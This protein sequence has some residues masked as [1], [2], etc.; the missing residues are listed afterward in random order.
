MSCENSKI[1]IR[2]RGVRGSHPMPGPSTLRYGGNTTCQEVRVDDRILIFDAGTGI[3]GLGNEL[4]KEGKPLSLAIFFSHNHHDHIDGIL[5]FKPAYQKS[6]TMHIFGPADE[7]GTIMDALE[8]LSSPAA[9]PVSFAHMGMKYSSTILNSG[10]VVIWRVGMEGP[11][12]WDGSYSPGPEDIVIRVLKNMLHP[13]EGV[14]NFRLEYGGKSYVYAT[15]VEGDGDGG[16]PD[17][18]EFARGAD[19]LAH[20]GQYTQEEYGIRRGWGHST[21]AMAIKTA[22]MA[23]V[24]RLAILHH[25]PEHD[26]AQL[27][28]MESEGKT[29]FPGMFMA[30]EGQI[31]CL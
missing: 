8:T 23:G 27:D 12:M 6:T 28:A 3:I 22:Q 14:L 16:D 29:I 15:D 24:P 1:Q 7:P 5:Y 30:R 20:D 19:L 11:E 10:D 31:I 13:L 17:L 21:I 2:I 4:V 9:H 18:A 25:D 26:D